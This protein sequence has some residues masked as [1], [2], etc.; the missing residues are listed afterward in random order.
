MTT[1]SRCPLCGGRALA[2]TRRTL[3]YASGRIRAFRWAC[4]FCGLLLDAPGQ[5]VRIAL[6]AALAG[7]HF[8]SPETAPFG[9]DIYTL[10]TAATAMTKRVEP[11][12][13]AQAEALALPHSALA[14]EARLKALEPS[15]GPGVSLG[16]LCRAADVE[17]LI[18]THRHH[19]AAFA[20][21]VLLVDGEGPEAVV[22]EGIRVAFRPLAR[23][24]AAQRGALQ[25]L[26]Q[27]A[28]MFQLDADETLTPETTALVPA[29][30]AL[31]DDGGVLSIGLPRRNL[32]DGVQADLYPDTQYRLNRREVRFMGPVHERPDRPWQRSFIALCGAIDHYLA[33][34]HVDTRSQSYEA[35]LPG[36]GR[37]EEAD[38]LRQRFR[39]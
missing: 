38:A 29:L 12:D 22:E 18:P 39:A 5:D 32:V 27:S 23:D 4:E 14:A 8:A 6:D 28:W 3:R 36:G 19:L 33:R 25:D 17:G 26:A 11:A 35:I 9:L 16:F 21:I 13:A 24:F 2:P 7:P 37:L 10:R 1:S 31:G 34:V 30:A 15:G 20:E